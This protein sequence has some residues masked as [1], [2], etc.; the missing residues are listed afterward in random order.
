MKIINAEEARKISREQPPDVMS[1]EAYLVH[2]SYLISS[3]APERR[4]QVNSVLPPRMNLAPIQTRLEE[5]GFKVVAEVAKGST[6]TITILHIS[7]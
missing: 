7:W 5:E 3:T 1:E 4:S 6:E 2:L